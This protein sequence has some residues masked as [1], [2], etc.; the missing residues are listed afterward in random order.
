MDESPIE[1]EDDVVFGMILMQ[2]SLKQG[3]KHFGKEN[4]EK[5]IMKEYQM[6]HDLNCFIPRDP[7]T[8]T[9]EERVKALSTVV[10]MK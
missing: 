10:F 8:L 6:L 2:M 5:S 7:K 9:R 3:I 1:V 4:A